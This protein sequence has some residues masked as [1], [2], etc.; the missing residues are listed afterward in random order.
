MKPVNGNL[1][2]AEIQVADRIQELRKDKG[3]TLRQLAGQADLSQ[4]Y[5]SRVENH[6]A[7]LPIAS[8]SRV[9]RALKAPMSAFFED[10]R[11]AKP[12]TVC[13]AGKGARGRLRGRGGLGYEMLAAEKTGKLI[14]PLLVDILS[15]RKPT[16]LHSHIGDEFNYVLR[17]SC[18]FHYGKEQI[19][20]ETGDAVYYDATVPH[21]VRLRSAR[22]TCRI[23]AVIASRDYLFHGDL[24]RL[25]NA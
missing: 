6:K 24:A 20:L 16:E 13:R 3:L 4:A 17:G 12:I 2:F 22:E 11:R 23:L 8:L 25:L 19:A 10:D 18:L 15:A 5:L 9:A 21:A 14:E 1:H 7:A